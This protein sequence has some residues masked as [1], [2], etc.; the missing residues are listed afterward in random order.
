MACMSRNSSWSAD[1]R[2]NPSKAEI[3]GVAHIW[4]LQYLYIYC[5]VLC[6][7]SWVA[8][9]RRKREPTEPDGGV[10]R[11]RV[12][13]NVLLSVWKPLIP[14]IPCALILYCDTRI[15]LGFYQTFIPVGSKLLYY[16]IYFFVGVGI[17][18]HREA[19]SLHARFGKTYVFIASLLFAAMLPL[20]H[21]HTTVALTGSR[22]ALTCGV[23]WPLFAWFA[24]FGLFAIFSADP[25]QRQRCDA[26]PVRGFVL[27][28]SDPFCHL[29]V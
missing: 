24:T 8:K 22:L 19:L 7:I 18:R 29:S 2:Q 27:D 21:E 14:A 4:F 13:D 20:I 10:P 5:L 6:G 3:C 16:A 11:F 23:C 12:L 15:V 25:A 1:C 26:I 28:L 17:N 9:Q